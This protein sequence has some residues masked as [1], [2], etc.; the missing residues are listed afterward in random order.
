MNKFLK[1]LLIFIFITSCSLQ[2]N[3]NFW[4]KK[5]IKVEKQENI[6]KIIKEEKKLNSEFNKNLRINL[7]S[8]VRNNSFLD[9]SNNDGRINFNGDLK[10]LSKYKF[11][12]IKNFY[13]YDPKLS[14]YNDDIIFFDSNGSIFRFDNNTNLVWKN[15]NYIKSE[16][17]QNLILFFTNNKKILVVAD[18][19]SKYYALDI[20][21]GKILWSKNN[22]APFNSE[23]KIY[24]DK[25]FVID[26][27]DTLRAF[28]IKN[29]DEIWNIKTQT[30]L[31]RSQK[32]L[33]IAITNNKI[34]FN[35]S[36]GDISAANIESGE[37]LWQTP[38]QSSLIIDSGFS[39]KTSNIVIKKNDLFF[40]NNKNQFFSLD[41]QTGNINWQQKVNSNLKPTL[42]DD[43][44][45]T[46][47]L[48]GY[49]VVIEKNSGEIIRITN[50]FQG[51]KD[52]VRNNIQP[53]GFIIGNNNIYLATDHGRLV[54]IDVAT[55]IP[56]NIMKINNGKINRPLVLN[57]NLFITTD[58]SII[59]LN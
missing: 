41:A 48:E 25:F 19:I 2:Q 31:I 24:K 58:N 12:K 20:D 23:I 10:S 22:S 33:S 52:K 39:L 43:Y 1:I 6:T 56:I 18:N 55:G 38:T 30:S 34:Y 7:F 35:N 9:N 50:I 59:K 13:Q 51:F 49:L 15:N 44:I 47:T 17:K 26:F 16:I 21:T 14:I 37:L 8:K 28:S 11:S 53:T 3:S 32:K 5:K 45:F 36:S 42:I 46:I 27:E 57:Q 40:S 4:T 54:V 29:G